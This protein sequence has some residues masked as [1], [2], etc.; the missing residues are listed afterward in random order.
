MEAEKSKLKPGERLSIDKI[1]EVALNV[2]RK[3]RAA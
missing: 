3:V 1:T 2:L